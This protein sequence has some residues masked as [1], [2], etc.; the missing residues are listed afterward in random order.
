MNEYT[1]SYD[2]ENCGRHFV[3]SFPKGTIARQPACPHCGVSQGQ[4]EMEKKEPW[5]AKYNAGKDNL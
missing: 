3:W 4:I 1:V 2:C 5:I